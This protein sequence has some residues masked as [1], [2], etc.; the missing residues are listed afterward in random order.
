MAA[1]ARK[2]GGTLSVQSKPAQGTRV[3]VDLPK[4]IHIPVMS[5]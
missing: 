4:K 5:P 1:R 2:L 3:V